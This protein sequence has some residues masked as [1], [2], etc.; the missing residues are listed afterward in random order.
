MA[1]SQRKAQKEKVEKLLI[2]NYW[3]ADAAAYY[4]CDQFWYAISREIPSDGAEEQKKH[5]VLL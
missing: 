3:V 2:E 4:V 1:T 5:I